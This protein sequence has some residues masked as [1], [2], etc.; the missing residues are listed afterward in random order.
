MFLARNTV[1]TLLLLS[2]SLILG[3]TKTARAGLDLEYTVTIEKGN[4]TV[5]VQLNI[6]NID[7]SYLPFEFRSEA[8][9]Q[10]IENYISNL[11]AE[12]DGSALIITDISEGKWRINSPGSTVTLQ[13][14]IA[15]IVPYNWS[16][17]LADNTEVAVYIDDEYGFLMGPF[18]FAYPFDS[19]DLSPEDISSIKIEFEVPNGWDVLTPYSEEGDHFTIEQSG[20]N[21]LS[22]FI[23]RQQIYMGKMKFYASKWVGNCKV[24]MGAPEGNDNV[25]EL[26]TQQDVQ[27][28]VNATA[29]VLAEYTRIFG[30]NPYSIYTM[31]PNFIENREGRQ[32]TFP[33]GRY[34]GNGWQY[35]PKRRRQDLVAHMALSFMLCWSDDVPLRVEYDIEK[36]IGE[37]YYGHT[38]AWSLFNDETDLGNMY[39]WYLVYDRMHG[40]ALIEHYEYTSYVKGEWVAL[41]LDKRIQE[42]TNGAKD[43]NTVINVLYRKYK[44]TDHTVTYH[45]LQEEVEF[46]TGSDFSTFFSQYI[47]SDDKIPAYQY[48]APYRGYFLNL[49]ATLENTYYL[50]LYGKTSPLFVLIE[51]ATNLQK[52]IWAGIFYQTHLDE[53]AAYVLAL[54]EIESITET[55]VEDALSELTNRDC[56]GFFDRWVNSFGRLSLTELK[57]WLSDY[58][59]DTNTPRCATGSATSLTANSAILNGTINPNGAITTYYFEYGTSSSYGSETTKANTGSGT[60]SIP[61]TTNLTGLN[62]NTTY[63][64]RIV[65]TNSAGTIKGGQKSFTT[66]AVA[67]TVCTTVATFVTSTSATLNGT[68]NPNGE[69]TTYYFEYGLDTSYGSPT[70]SASAGSGTSAVSVNAAI[71]GLNSDT[72][73]HYRVVATNSDGTS[74]GDDKTFNTTIVYVELSGSCGGKTPC[75]STIQAAIGAASSGATIKIVEGTYS[76]NLSLNSAKELILSGGW[77]S[78]FSTQAGNSTITS[79][80]I[81]NGTAIFENIVIQ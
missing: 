43:L 47:D 30:D 38:L 22:A 51:M 61:V 29:L 55:N 52:H 70:S 77:D 80:T 72:T 33:G 5:H 81:D 11:S 31:Y 35:W 71:S 3:F 4:D 25:W 67:P 75:Y 26:Q 66:S 58:K 1:I 69:A 56:S 12:S 32:Y 20:T 28:H 54:H 60:N 42:A 37:M 9:D 21:L 79:L 40:T 18:F 14:D 24:Q 36:G 2:G 65:A 44:Q 48:V 76:E 19:T 16:H 57:E 41:L 8:R 23:K 46:I 34:F 6:S 63:Y 53:F 7:T 13:Y 73:Y 10:N 64:C 59:N 78:T 17:L 68:V 45:D 62:S 49:P 39:Y 27:D 74:Y 15:R 50:E